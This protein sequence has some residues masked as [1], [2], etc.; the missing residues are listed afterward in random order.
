[1]LEFPGG[2]E[3]A[4][5]LGVFMRSKVVFFNFLFALSVS[6]LILPKPEKVI[7]FMGVLKFLHLLG[8]KDCGGGILK[9]PYGSFLCYYKFAELPTRSVCPCLRTCVRIK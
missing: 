2:N 7:N 4:H 3:I 6:D 1:M 5:L 9:R 8:K